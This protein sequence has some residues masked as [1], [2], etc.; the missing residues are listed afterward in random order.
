MKEQGNAMARG[1]ETKA[2][3]PAVKFYCPSCARATAYQVPTVW[4][5]SV[6]LRC[7]HCGEVYYVG[8]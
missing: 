5:R 7:V 8:Q 4:P 2:G 1:S 3:R 6:R